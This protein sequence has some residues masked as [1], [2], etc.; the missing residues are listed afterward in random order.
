[1]SKASS[2]PAELDAL[3]AAPKQHQLVLENTKVRVLDTK[4]APSET[5]PIHT[6]QWPAAHYVLSWSD[7]VRRDGEGNVLLDSRTSDKSPPSAIWTDADGP[8]SIE[9]VGASDLHVVSVEV[10]TQAS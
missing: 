1:M 6:H 2:W 7:F 5:T 8:H 9:N 3:I 10:K 4:I